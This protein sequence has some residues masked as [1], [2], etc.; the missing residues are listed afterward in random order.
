MVYKWQD[1][2]T[3]KY[4]EVERTLKESDI[5]PDKDEVGGILTIEE[6][7]EADWAKIIQVTYVS[8]SDSW[9]SKGNM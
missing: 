6:F 2:N 5:P 1:L 7:A 8:R 3:E 4:I 9:G